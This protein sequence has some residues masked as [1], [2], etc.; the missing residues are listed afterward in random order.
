[1]ADPP[2]SG[3]ATMRRNGCG[4]LRAARRSARPRPDARPSRRLRDGGDGDKLKDNSIF[5]ESP[6]VNTYPEHGLRL[7]L[8][9][10]L[11]LLFGLR[12]IVVAPQPSEY[13]G[14]LGHGQR[15]VMGV[16]AE[17]EMKIVALQLQR[18]RQLDV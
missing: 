4:A 16:V 10:L 8:R 13:F 1:M 12:R 9:A 3:G 11:V 2:R 5:R 6:V 15:R 14:Q 7:L 17:A 18:I